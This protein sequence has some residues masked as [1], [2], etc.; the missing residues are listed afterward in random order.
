MP[1]STIECVRLF[2]EIASYA[3]APLAL[4]LAV[5]VAV[6]RWRDVFRSDLR[7]RQ[8]EELATV[9]QQL[10]DIWFELGCLPD[11]RR[12]MEIHEWNLDDL[13][14]KAPEE[15]AGYKR[16][17]SCSRR[18]FYK[19]QYPSYFLFPSW[20]DT[21]RVATLKSTMSKF[22]PFTLMSS[23]D[24]GDALRHQY[25]NEMLA[26]IDYLDEQIRSHY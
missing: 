18:V 9:R 13:R 4:F 7:K 23:T 5:G 12:T 6:I 15:W 26:F 21:T 22:V 14:D 10:H 8:L 1:D 25:L 2:A 17:S 19:L 11:T 3:S 24:R 16:Y 20:L